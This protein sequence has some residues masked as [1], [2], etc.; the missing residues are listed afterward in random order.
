MLSIIIPTLNEENYLPRL[1]GC[2][3]RQKEWKGD[4][5][6][7]IADAGSQDK[8]REIAQAFNYKVVKGGLPAK[9]RNQGAKEAQGEMLLFLDA[10]VVLSEDFFKKAME[11]FKER[12][13]AVAAFSLIPLS[14]KMWFQF[15]FNFF[16][17]YPLKIFE[18]K[19]AHGAMGILVK[20]DLHETLG[21]F[22][23]EIKIAED[24]HYVQEAAKIRKFGM[25]KS[26]KIFVSMRRFEKESWL[27]IGYKYSFTEIYM[28]LKGP[29]R[30]EFFQYKF[31]HYDK[32]N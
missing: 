32:K 14:E 24:H 9:G 2:L 30:K 20:K 22:D 19:W 15:L 8:T 26:T 6:V 29:V 25:I 4:Y 16:Y 27:K 31:N 17:N 23:E 10:D 1:L 18:D 13:L 28:K 11:E 7:I 3:R 5:E 21:G 12:D